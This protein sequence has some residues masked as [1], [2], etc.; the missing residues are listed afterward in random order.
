MQWL[1]ALPFATWTI[2]GGVWIWTGF[3]KAKMDKALFKL[4]MESEEKMAEYMQHRMD[5]IERKGL[6]H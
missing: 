5:T 1:Q 4:H 2:A 3:R 6:T